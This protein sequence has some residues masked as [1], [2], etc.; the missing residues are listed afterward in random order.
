MVSCVIFFALFDVCDRSSTHTHARAR[1]FS[2][3][4]KCSQTKAPLRN[5]SDLHLMKMKKATQLT[6]KCRNYLM[7]ARVKLKDLKSLLLRAEDLKLRR[8]RICVEI[9]HICERWEDEWRGPKQEETPHITYYPRKPL[10]HCECSL[11]K[12]PRRHEAPWKSE[13]EAY[14]DRFA[15]S[16][17]NKGF[18][19]SGSFHGKVEAKDLHWPESYRN[20]LPLNFRSV[21]IVQI[22]RCWKLCLKLF[23]SILQRDLIVNVMDVVAIKLHF[24]RLRFKVQLTC[25]VNSLCSACKN[26]Q[27][28]VFFPNGSCIFSC[29]ELQAFDTWCCVVTKSMKGTVRFSVHEIPQWSRCDC[30]W[31]PRLMF[32]TGHWQGLN[33]LVSSQICRPS[34]LG[35][36]IHNR[37]GIKTVREQPNR[38]E[39]QRLWL[40]QTAFQCN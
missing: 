9:L 13:Y 35:C 4:F 1:F 7:T 11:M 26:V 37:A 21:A 5:S 34:G 28:P 3:T 2:S 25:P 6:C 10:Q 16:T 38:P 12:T 27:L 39:K 24:H 40:R 18:L 36:F 23:F 14:S 22:Q 15:S 30:E 29:L 20:S 33:S 17:S 32:S 19:K 8:Q 31:T